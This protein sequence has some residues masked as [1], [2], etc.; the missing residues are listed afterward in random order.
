MALLSNYFNKEY[1]RQV[2]AKE[3][4]EKKEELI[5]KF[6]LDVF[7][8]GKHYFEENKRVEQAYKCILN[9]DEDGFVK[10]IN[11]S[12]E[13]SFYQLKNCYVN[14]IEENLPQGILK[15]K[16]YLTSGGVRVHGGGFAGTILA[17]V[18]K[19]ETK[20]YISK[21]KEMFGE[22]N[23][24]QIYLA[25]YGTRHIGKIENILEE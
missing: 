7:N 19:K 21:M 24:K 4:F 1:L 3:F 23:V 16:E 8:R 25:K 13:S 12:G 18:N 22:Q 5:D 9:N 20:E 6:G 14:S 11:D 10:C 17:F 2:R 15:S